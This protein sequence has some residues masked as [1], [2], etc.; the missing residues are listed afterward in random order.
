[1]ICDA[2]KLCC[3]LA[4]LTLCPSLSTTVSFAAQ[5]NFSTIPGSFKPTTDAVTGKYASD[6]GRKYVECALVAE[7]QDGDLSARSTAV[8]ELPSKTG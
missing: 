7:N 2:R 4:L 8:A 3:A 1:M 5:N 6:D